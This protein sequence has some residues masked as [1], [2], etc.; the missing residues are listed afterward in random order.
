VVIG[1]AVVRWRIHKEAK[2]GAVQR[3]HGKL[4]MIG[5]KTAFRAF[6]CPRP[7]EL[8]SVSKRSHFYQNHLFTME[9]FVEKHDSLI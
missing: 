2:I 6:L 8:P 5:H 9:T 3:G 1:G 7:K 4:P